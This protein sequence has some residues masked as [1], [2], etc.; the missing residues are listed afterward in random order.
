M[1]WGG[2]LAALSLLLLYLATMLPSGRIGMVA[3]AGLVPA[4]GVISG[5]LATG[6][7]SYGAAGL[8]GLLLL[9]DKGSAL[10]YVLFFG[11]YPM[12]KYLIERLRKLP[13]ELVL[14]LVFFNLILIAMIAFGLWLIK[15]FV[16]REGTKNVILIIAAAFTIVFHYSLL[17]FK[18]LSGEDAIAYLGETPNLLLPIY[19]CNVVMWS[20]LIFA[21]LKNKKSKIGEFFSDYVFWFGLISTL[22][23]MFANVDFINNP[24]LADYENVKSIGAHAT[25]LFNLLLLPIFGYVKIDVVRNIKNIVI[26]IVMMALIGGY[27]NLVFGALVSEA[28]AYDVNSMF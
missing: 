13:L 24:T 5:G 27:C 14:K 10:L 25:L 20:A 21:C 9:P 3:V 23:G 2:V 1:A 12:I 22:V 8:L 11:L 17:I 4:V 19:P 7:L 16:K 15:R 18:L 26:S 28:S 6:F